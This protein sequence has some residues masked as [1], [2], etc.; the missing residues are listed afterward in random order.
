M[1]KHKLEQ[2]L[3]G[4]PDLAPV[5]RPQILAISV[6]TERQKDCHHPQVQTLPTRIM[7]QRPPTLGMSVLQEG[8][9]L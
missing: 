3:K 2:D 5:M 4:P 7:L 8:L 1:F 9:C 6:S